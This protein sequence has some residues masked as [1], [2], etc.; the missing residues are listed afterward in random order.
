MS[1][2]L[3]KHFVQF[4]FDS[5]SDFNLNDCPRV[6][7]S[8]MYGQLI[9]EWI[10]QSSVAPWQEGLRVGISSVGFNNSTSLKPVLWVSIS[11]WV[12][13]K[14][15]STTQQINTTSVGMVHLLLERWTYP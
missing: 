8:S 4:H 10:R 6:T 1:E 12:W 5:S 13:N 2:I 7:Q 9:W 14:P 3:D 15:R 11:K